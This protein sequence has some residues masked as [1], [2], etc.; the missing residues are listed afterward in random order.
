M[1]K[2]SISRSIILPVAIVVVGIAAAAVLSGQIERCSSRD[3]RGLRGQRPSR[4]TAPPLRA[5]H[6]AWK[7]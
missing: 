6:L 7:A 4:C 2:S 5:T 3:A 1:M